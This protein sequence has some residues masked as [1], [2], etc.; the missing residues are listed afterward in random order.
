MPG[1]SGPSPGVDANYCVLYMLCTSVQIL[2]EAFRL[3]WRV[4]THCL[5]TGPAPKSRHDRLAVYCETTTELDM[6]T[7]VWTRGR[8]VSARSLSL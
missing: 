1:L 2:G 8:G 7:L 6:K 5:V 4:R 3:G